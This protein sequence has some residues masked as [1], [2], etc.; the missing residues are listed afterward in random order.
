MRDAIRSFNKSK[1]GDVDGGPRILYQLAVGGEAPNG[2]VERRDHVRLPASGDRQ[3]TSPG[4]QSDNAIR[5]V[6][7]LQDFVDC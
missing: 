2:F 4:E 3:D 1:R 5:E 7:V 6:L